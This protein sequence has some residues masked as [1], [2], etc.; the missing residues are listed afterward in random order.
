MACLIQHGTL[1]TYLVLVKNVQNILVAN[2]QIIF[3]FRFSWDLWEKRIR[4]IEL[5]KTFDFPGH[6]GGKTFQ[7][8]YLPFSNFAEKLCGENKKN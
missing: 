5:L 3:L 6:L 7:M 8:N 4:F 2:F 1:Q